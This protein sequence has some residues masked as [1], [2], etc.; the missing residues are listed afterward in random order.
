MS[1]IVVSD[2]DKLDSCEKAITQAYWKVGEALRTI[3]DDRLY[4]L[5]YASFEEYCLKKWNYTDSRARQ[6]IAAAK[7]HIEIEG[8]TG[9]TL[10]NEQ[11]ARAANSL[12]ASV[13]AN[14]VVVA[15]TNG[16]LTAS[17]I[18]EEGAKLAAERT[19][20]ETARDV[21]YAS[22]YSPII[23]KMKMGILTPQNAL[24]LVDTLKAC[25]PVVRGDMFRLS[26]TDVT[27]IRMLNERWKSETY[28]ELV[29]SGY[30]QF[31][32]ERTYK[33]EQLTPQILRDYLD[34]R[35]R[36]HRTR[37][38]LESNQKRGVEI[39]P[40]NIYRGDPK[41]TADVLLREL[42][43]EDIT[44]IVNL[45]EAKLKAAKPAA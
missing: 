41:Q 32:D 37:G 43:I 42:D 38:H 35:A 17:A 2:R 3:R 29:T 22:K 9:V 25:K 33:A 45:L 19:P 10:S 16:P 27:V 20:D 11:Q 4:L 39:V 14:A 36:E 40:V 30:I 5:D 28:K 18:K 8:V 24:L 23:Q 21:V 13:R 34:E 12:P 7:V 26:I 31:N 15:A 44:E 1:E 6:F